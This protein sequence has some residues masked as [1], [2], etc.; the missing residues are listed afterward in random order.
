MRELRPRETMGLADIL[1]GRDGKAS[2]T[3]KTVCFSL[4][5]YSPECQPPSRHTVRKTD[6]WADSQVGTKY[7]NYKQ[8]WL[9]IT[10]LYLNVFFKWGKGEDAF[11]QKGIFWT[12]Q[13]LADLKRKLLF[14]EILNCT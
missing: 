2:A 14:L 11:R 8:E 4:P 5:H 6:K 1:Y 10:H 13:C 9:G 12:H 3:N 7:C